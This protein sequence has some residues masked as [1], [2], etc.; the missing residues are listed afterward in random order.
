MALSKQTLQGIVIGVVAGFICGFA[1]RSATISS[2]SAANPILAR[3][4]NHSIRLSDIEARVSAD[5]EV[6]KKNEYQLQRQAIEALVHEKV[7]SENPELAPSESSLKEVEITEDEILRFAKE[8]QL[9]LKPGDSQARKN[10]VGNLK[11]QKAKA[12]SKPEIEKK[13]AE[14]KWMIAPPHRSVSLDH[15]RF[16]PA[17]VELSIIERLKSVWTKKHLIIAVGNFHCPFC[18]QAEKNFRDLRN[19]YGNTSAVYYRF[20]M[21]ENDISITAASAEA[22]YCAEKQGKFWSFRDLL[23]Q[24]PP[25][26]NADLLLAAKSAG[27]EEEM[28]SKCLSDRTLKTEFQQ[29]L[30]AIRSM[31][32]DSG[33]YFVING[34]MISGHAPMAEIEAL[35]IK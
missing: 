34:Q 7:L 32:I 9:N 26:Q 16:P 1:V 6:L 13:Q 30:L 3:Y 27:L 22:S 5:L 31:G 10:I 14:I 21:D 20:L 28:F 25:V 11:L 4:Q 23:S 12:K 15:G 2:N 17:P 35:L 24:K 18:P 29:D 33:P 19:R 8:R